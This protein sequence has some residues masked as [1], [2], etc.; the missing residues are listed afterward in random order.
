MLTK[1]SSRRETREKC[2]VQTKERRKT[3][4]KGVNIENSYWM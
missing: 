1:R 2:V 3:E 4:G